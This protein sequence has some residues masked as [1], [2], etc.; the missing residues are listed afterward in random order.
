MRARTRKGQHEL[1]CALQTRHQL[2]VNA[3][4]TL[5]STLEDKPISSVSSKAEFA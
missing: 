5:P 2:S 4:R 1:T 3:F